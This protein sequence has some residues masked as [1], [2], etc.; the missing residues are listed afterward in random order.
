MPSHRF[1]HPDA[2]APIED[3]LDPVVEFKPLDAA[4]WCSR[5][6]WTKEEAASISLGV[7]PEIASSVPDW[8]DFQD[9]M[10]ERLIVI[11]RGQE[12]DELKERIRPT[13][14][15]AWAS[16]R[17]I[18]LADELIAA[19]GDTAKE[20]EELGR[21]RQEN[22]ALRRDAER[23]SGTIEELQKENQNL[24]RQ[25][26][27]PF[28]TARNSY[29]KMIAAMSKKR[30]GYARD[31]N[32]QAASKILSDALELGLSIDLSVVKKHLDD[33]SALIPEDKT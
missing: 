11:G 26:E 27:D 10:A 17:G 22:E 5:P 16:G 31:K 14:F 2:D 7:D 18:T 15:V 23:M 28:A 9:G 13:E 25:N 1:R 32:T 24:K 4:R 19:L 20:A 30:Y 8:H 21:L 12:L 29:W 6:Y 33:A 3:V